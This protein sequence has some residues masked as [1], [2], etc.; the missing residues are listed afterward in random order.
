MRLLILVAFAAIAYY[1]WTKVSGNA[2]NPFSKKAEAQRQ[3]AK[4]L[5]LSRGNEE[6][7]LRMYEREK[8]EYPDLEEWGILTRIAEKLS[9]DR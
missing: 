2:S 1:I 3:K 6:S 4:I 7:F 5:L 9:N 8:S